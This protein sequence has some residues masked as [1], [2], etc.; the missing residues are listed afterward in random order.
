MKYNLTNET[1]TSDMMSS[2]PAAPRMTVMD[3]LGASLY[4]TFFPL[5]IDFCLVSWIQKTLTK[6]SKS[7]V[8]AFLLLGIVLHLPIILFW[9]FMNSQGAIILNTASKIGLLASMPFAGFFW[10]IVNLKPIPKA[11]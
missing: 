9:I 10:M 2:F 1:Y 6:N 3:M 5:L 7:N 11:V 4:I 8:P